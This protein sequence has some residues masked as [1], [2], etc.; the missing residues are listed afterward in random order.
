M[1]SLR[2]LQEKKGIKILLLIEELPE[3]NILRL[4]LSHYIKLI[5]TMSPI[6]EWDLKLILEDI[7]LL[8]RLILR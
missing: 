6:C 8:R 4:N 5:Y 2:K 1:E 3:N 7:R